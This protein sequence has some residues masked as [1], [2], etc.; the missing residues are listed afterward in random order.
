[1]ITSLFANERTDF[2][3]VHYRLQGAPLVPKPLQDPLPIMIG[4]RGERRTV[5]TMVRWGHEWN[6]WCTPRDMGHYNALIDRLC[7]GAG[8]DP[9]TIA[10]SAATLLFLCDSEAGGGPGES[11]TFGDAPAGGHARPACRAGGPLCRGRHRRADH[12]RLQPRAQRDPRSS[13]ALHV[14]GSRQPSEPPQASPSGSRGE[15]FSYTI[16]C[17]MCGN[18]SNARPETPHCLRRGSST[19]S[20]IVVQSYGGCRRALDLGLNAYVYGPPW[21]RPNVLPSASRAGPAARRALRPS[22]RGLKT[23]SGRLDRNRAEQ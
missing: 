12:P 8:R 18:A 1:M 11:T 10:R 21:Q 17:K 14:R 2:D 5:P 23:L 6:G 16:N 13:R 9:G 7:E 20:R 22:V 4:G 3:G 19:C 15:L